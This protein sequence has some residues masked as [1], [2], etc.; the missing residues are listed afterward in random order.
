MR[1]TSRWCERSIEVCLWR[2]VR[3]LEGPQR[4]VD[5]MM[6]FCSEGESWRR[7]SNGV[8]VKVLS[9]GAVREKET[10]VPMFLA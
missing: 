3:A 4:E 10:E 7:E 9:M 1:G 6:V 8:V 2:E 5:I